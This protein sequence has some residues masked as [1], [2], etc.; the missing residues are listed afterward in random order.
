MNFSFPN[1]YGRKPI[2]PGTSEEVA[3]AI[4]L[5][6]VSVPKDWLLKGGLSK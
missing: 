3:S 1:I 5:Q 6:D 2:A 4:K